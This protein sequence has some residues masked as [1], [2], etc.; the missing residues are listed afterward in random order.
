MPTWDVQGKAAFDAKFN[1]VI[2]MSLMRALK[3]DLAT[4]KDVDAVK[5]I[6]SDLTNAVQY[7]SYL[8]LSNNTFDV[9]TS[10]DAAIDAAVDSNYNLLKVLYK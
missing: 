9:S 10:T 6:L 2:L 7:M 3:N 8:V 5:N 4:S 1:R